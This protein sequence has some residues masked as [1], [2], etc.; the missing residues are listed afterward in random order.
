[1]KLFLNP[2]HILDA[3]TQTN[4]VSDGTNGFHKEEPTTRPGNLFTEAV[5]DDFHSSEKT[6]YKIPLVTYGQSENRRMKVITIGAGFSG[7]MLAYHIE[8]QC[9]N[10]EH[11]IY[12]K[13]PDVGGTWI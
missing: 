1:M 3:M 9:S 13:N 10:V 7:I 4:G 12:E 6:G 5:S 8:K 2:L 11:I